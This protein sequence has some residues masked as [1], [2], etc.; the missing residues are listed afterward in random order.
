MPRISREGWATFLS[1]VFALATT[2]TPAIQSW[3]FAGPLWILFL[4]CGY[5]WWTTEETSQR[6]L[7]DIS[8]ETQDKTSAD[9]ALVVLAY[10]QNM[11][12]AQNVGTRLAR[13]ITI[14]AVRFEDGTVVTF[15]LPSDLLAGEDKP[16]AVWVSTQDGVT[17]A[18]D[19]AEG[20]EPFL[21]SVIS[22]RRLAGSVWP[23]EIRYREHEGTARTTLME[24]FCSGTS[25]CGFRLR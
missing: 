6:I 13:E 8:A 4:Y 21:G 5:R 10:K 24:L 1:G 3:W 23:V 2:V 25:S 15:D 18:D 7:G 11:V 14:D 17:L 19:T 12:L 16:V 22:N 9:R 20:G